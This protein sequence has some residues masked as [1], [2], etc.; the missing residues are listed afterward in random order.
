MNKTNNY[1]TTIGLEIHVQLK[2]DTKMFCRCSNKSE[3]SE[4]NSNVCPICL[5]MPGTLPV[6]N[7][8]AVSFTA[9]TGLAL[10]CDINSQSK[11]D[12]KHYFYPDLPKG[13]QI[14]QY[15]KPIAKNGQL[16]TSAGKVGINRVHLEEDAGKLIHP[17]GSS[18]SLVDL[19]RAGTPLMEIVTEP[20]IISP[21]QAKEFL[22]LLKYTVIYLGVSNASME[23]GHLRVDANIS[24]QKEGKTTNI[25]EIKNMN[26]FRAVEQALT[27]EQKRLQNNFNKFSRKKTKE[28]RGWQADKKETI[29]QREKEE[30]ADYRYF[31]EPDIPPLKFNQ[32]EIDKIKN[33]LPILPVDIRKQFKKQ[34]LK[35]EDF[36]SII[37]D[38]QLFRYYLKVSKQLDK[39]MLK[40][41][42][43]WLANEQVSL[44]I[45]PKH[46]ADFVVLVAE[47]KLPGP[48]AKQVLTL[49][50][51][52]D[53][54]PAD[55]I[56]SAGLS[57]QT[58]SKLNSTI[59]QIIKENKDAAED[60][61]AGNLGII[62]FLIGQV[63]AKT[64]GQANPKE[65]K[66]ILESKLK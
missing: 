6:T 10:G 14:S 2:T 48:M 32:N 31:P 38:P 13:F 18:E 57:P 9:R 36:W 51:K 1:K 33:S 43:N 50:T 65:V 34:G 16:E 17:K 35:D 44:E 58:G 64:K 26:S 66:K 55:I 3:D 25:V 41:L 5:G 49:M 54:P 62:Q 28:T 11:F 46:F 60:Y 40:N 47:G 45:K 19:N 52:N 37:K 8:K 39:K 24:V 53:K 15:D 23:K 4:P 56:K 27:Y 21:E 30:A 59:D 12:R 61:K 22:R 42:A 7:K 20:D 29:P 63:M